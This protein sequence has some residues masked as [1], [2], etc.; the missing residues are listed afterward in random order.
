M[1]ARRRYGH[2]FAGV[3][4]TPRGKTAFVPRRR[5]NSV[6]EPKKFL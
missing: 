5:E 2:V 4:Q 3:F 6:S 1:I